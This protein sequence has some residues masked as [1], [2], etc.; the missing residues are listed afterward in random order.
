[1]PFFGLGRYQIASGLRRRF[2]IL[3][4]ISGAAQGDQGL[5]GAGWVARLAFFPTP[6]AILV[7]PFQKVSNGVGIPGAQHEIEHLPF[8]GQSRGAFFPRFGRV[9]G[10]DFAAFQGEISPPDWK[11]TV[12]QLRADLAAATVRLVSS[13]RL[14]FDWTLQFPSRLRES[15]GEPCPHWAR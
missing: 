13:C 11:P 14:R 3:R 7:L 5:S 4:S 2:G 9:G 12:F 10:L 1:M 15:F 6:S 8:G